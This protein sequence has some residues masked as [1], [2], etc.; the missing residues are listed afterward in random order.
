MSGCIVKRLPGNLV[1]KSG[2]RIQLDE[3]DALSLAAKLQLPVPRVYESERT[4]EGTISIRMD[5]IE[6]SRLDDAWPDMTAG[7]KVDVCGQLKQI[8]KDMRSIKSEDGIIGSCSGGLVRDCRRYDTYTGGPFDNE[9]SFNNFILDFLKA[10]PTPI[11]NAIARQLVPNHRIVFSHGDLVMH[12]IIV[13]G[14]KI[15]GLIDW[16]YAGWYP[17]Y[18]E[19]VKFFERHSNHP[20]WK[21][22]AAYIF[23]QAY[24][25]ELVAYQALIRWQLP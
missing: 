12:N 17:E 6:G 24:D 5:F 14:S 10:T 2:S 4:L 1:V 20:D 18:W 22:H 7:E 23:P 25:S 3:C 19:Y 21:D 13:K 8:L 15:M 11:R 9:D 16:E